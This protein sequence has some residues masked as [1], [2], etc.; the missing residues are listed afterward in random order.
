MDTTGH[1]TSL[2]RANIALTVKGNK[3]RISFEGTSPEHEGSYH[4][5]TSVIRAHCA[6]NLFEFPFHDFP[7]SSGMMEHIDIDVPAGSFFGA[8]PEAA[9]SLLTPGRCSRVPAAR[10]GALQGHVFLGAA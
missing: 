6:V 9:I 10:F 8:S 2:L 1:E 3:V 4:A 7:L 5:L